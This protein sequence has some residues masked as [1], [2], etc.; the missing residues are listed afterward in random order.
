MICAL[1]TR[2][3]DGYYI[4]AEWVGYGGCGIAK[5]FEFEGIDLKKELDNMRI[6]ESK[7]WNIGYFLNDFCPRK[8][9]P[10]KI[11]K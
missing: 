11:I 10:G 6:G 1:V 4:D 7:V 5:A 9:L 2:R 3:E 8:Y